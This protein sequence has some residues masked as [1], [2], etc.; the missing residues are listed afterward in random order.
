MDD[1]TIKALR[2][3]G[4]PAGLAARL[5]ISRQAVRQW[6]KVP[7]KRVPAVE[8]IT[9]VPRHQL[10]P[11]VYGNSGLRPSTECE[12]RARALELVI[13]SGAPLNDHFGLADK[14][15]SF[16]KGDADPGSADQ[17]PRTP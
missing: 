14:I 1:V 12:I 10:R 16:L 6:R 4:G 5:G 9:G 13:K 11:D 3:A 17:G 8:Q 15:L 7:T 2:A